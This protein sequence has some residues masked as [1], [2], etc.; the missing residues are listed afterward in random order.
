MQVIRRHVLIQAFE[1]NVPDQL[2]MKARL[3]MGRY[4]PSSFW[5]SE[6]F[7]SNGVTRAVLNC[8]GNVPVISDAFT[9]VKRNET[10][11]RYKMERS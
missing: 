9:T 7:F 10:V 3:E 8:L 11:K 1:D 2:P 6:A 5:S 4:F